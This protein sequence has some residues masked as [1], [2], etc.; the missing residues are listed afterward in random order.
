MCIA[1]IKSAAASKQGLTSA[2][3]VTDC[4]CEHTQWHQHWA[5]LLSIYWQEHDGRPESVCRLRTPKTGC[6]LQG[7]WL[8][9]NLLGTVVLLPAKYDE[10]SKRLVQRER[11]PLQ[12]CKD[13]LSPPLRAKQPVAGSKRPACEVEQL[14]RR[15]W[16]TGCQG[17]RDLDFH[18]LTLPMSVGTY[19]LSEINF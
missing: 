15:C 11:R 5:V 6:M 7:L 17:R 4:D 13:V 12:P 18:A 19:R 10:S 8:V 14:S 2:R 1:A 16:C 3:Y 9:C